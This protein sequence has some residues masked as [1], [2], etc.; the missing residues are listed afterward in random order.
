MC[1]CTCPSGRF[2]FSNVHRI[3]LSIPSWKR[4]IRPNSHYLQSS[5]RVGGGML[6]GSALGVAARSEVCLHILIHQ[7]AASIRSC[8]NK[9]E[10]TWTI[11]RSTCFCLPVLDTKHDA[12]WQ[13]ERPAP[14]ESGNYAIPIGICYFLVS[15][16]PTGK[17]SVT[18][19]GADMIYHRRRVEVFV[20]PSIL[21]QTTLH[22]CLGV[23]HKGLHCSH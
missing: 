16:Y 18:P 11:Q 13:Q 23:H 20:H 7:P 10:E 9:T 3:V 15:F 21:N 8:C 4:L 22:A 2:F 6:F 19:G 14:L 5:S 12:A 1:G 17:I